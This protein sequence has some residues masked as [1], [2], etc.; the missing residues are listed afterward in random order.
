MLEKSKIELNERYALRFLWARLGVCLALI[1][2]VTVLT[3]AGRIATETT[4]VTLMATLGIIIWGK[5]SG[6]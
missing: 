5:N 2:A 1:I 4:I 3:V 6:A